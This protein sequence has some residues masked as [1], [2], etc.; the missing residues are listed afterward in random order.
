MTAN[1]DSLS[2]LSFETI[3]RVT[4]PDSP[5]EQPDVD[6]EIKGVETLSKTYPITKLRF[7][8]VSN[9]VEEKRRAKRCT[10]GNGI[11]S[12][13]PS[14]LPDG[15]RPR[16]PIYA[17]GLFALQ[18]PQCPEGTSD[19]DRAKLEKIPASLCLPDFWALNLNTGSDAYVSDAY[20]DKST[21][22]SIFDM[23]H[24]IMSFFGTMIDGMGN[25][26]GIEITQ[27]LSLDTSHVAVMKVKLTPRF[28]GGRMTIMAGIDGMPVEPGTG[29][30]KD[31]VL[32][33]VANDRLVLYE[34]KT[35]ENQPVALAQRAELFNEGLAATVAGPTTVIDEKDRRIWQ[36]F[37]VDNEVPGEVHELVVITSVHTG[38]DQGILGGAQYSPVDAAI[39]EAAGA[40]QYRELLDSQTRSWDKLLGE[41]SLNIVGDDELARA[42]NFNNIHTLAKVGTAGYPYAGLGAKSSQDS[43][44]FFEPGIDIEG[45]TIKYLN[46]YHGYGG[47]D[48]WDTLIF[49]LPALT[50]EQQKPLLSYRYNQLDEARKKAKNAGYEGAWYPWESTLPGHGEACPSW[51]YNSS[52]A[53]VKIVMAEQSVHISADVAYATMRYYRATGDKEFLRYKGAE[54]VIEATRFLISRATK[55]EDGKYIYEHVTGPDEYHEDVTN[56]A[57]TVLM[58]AHTMQLAKELFEEDGEFRD[59]LKRRLDITDDELD[60]W[61]HVRQNLYIPFDPD[62]LVFKAFDGWEDLEHIDLQRDYPGV[63]IM[64]AALQRD[65]IPENVRNNPQVLAALSREEINP[66]CKTDVIKQHDT[67][68]ALVL[69]GEQVLDFLPEDIV[70]QL[71]VSYGG[72]RGKLMEE[73]YKAN[74]KE[75]AEVSDGSSLSPSTGVL[76][77]LAAGEDPDEHYDDFRN[78]AQMDLV[79]DT[80]GTDEGLHL[81]NMAAAVCVATEGFMGIKVANG[82]L[83]VNPRMP[84]VWQSA[85]RVVSYK[86]EKVK[87]YINNEGYVSIK[88]LEPSDGAN[89]PVAIKGH[90]Y[91][92][93]PEA[94]AV[95]FREN[96]GSM[97]NVALEEAMMVA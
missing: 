42:L 89:I 39:K 77:A 32:R 12:Y 68:L 72:D 81:A 83:N 95:T 59:E 58:A 10:V 78:L 86:G 69:L 55:N 51:T 31:T 41:S 66:V 3:P 15:E 92:L 64:D 50:P 40:S 11:L 71:L 57:Y 56:N 21:L 52:G 88:L 96:L 46:E 9:R 2:S 60:Y 70:N 30:Y 35:T 24:N 33:P 34:A 25:E 76:A 27:F 6:N 80:H 97:G 91:T 61:N 54:I 67:V 43:S 93:T 45:V 18:Y 90:K 26:T 5:D 87:I 48:F 44:E 7:E 75:Y 8:G 14:P 13:P 94:R 19:E 22:L 1:P 17:R 49:V 37:T 36:S 82:R 73:I 65:R 38:A 62:T 85:E 23:E 29:H 63:T 20:V 4:N 16:P 47:H 79:H 84:S 74:R 28:K 53:L